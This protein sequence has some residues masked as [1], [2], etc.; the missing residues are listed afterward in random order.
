MPGQS[1]FLIQF[2]R[3]AG[4]FWNSE[5]KAI[6]RS[7]SLALIVLTALQVVIVVIMTEWSAALFPMR[8]EQRSMSGLFRQAGIAVLILAVNM[9]VWFMH[10]KVTR[11]LQNR[12]AIL[13]DGARHRSMDEQWPS[14]PGY[15]L[16]DSGT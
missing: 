14:L 6:I 16:A 15:S 2:M 8:F 10:V 13:A 12:L 3:L 11:H 5:N 9:A 1:G 7:R 4:P